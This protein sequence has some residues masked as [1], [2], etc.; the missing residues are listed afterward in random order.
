MCASCCPATRFQGLH[1][2]NLVCRTAPL[3]YRSLRRSLAV[4]EL[5]VDR[6]ALGLDG[7]GTGSPV[8]VLGTRTSVIVSLTW[9]GVP[10]LALCVAW[11]LRTS[12]AKGETI[13]ARIEDSK[14]GFSRWT[15]FLGETL[16]TRVK[17]AEHLS[18]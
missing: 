10:S 16:K 1:R 9:T 2:R 4:L 17:T 12:G 14:T 6:R 11:Y 3:S 7:T 13:E 15:V 18:S 5:A 8:E